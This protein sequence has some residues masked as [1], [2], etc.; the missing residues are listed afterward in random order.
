MRFSAGYETDWIDWKDWCIGCCWETCVSH[1]KNYQ[2][3]LRSSCFFLQ[4]LYNLDV[5]SEKETAR[6][7]S[8]SNWEIHVCYW[9]FFLRKAKKCIRFLCDI[10]IKIVFEFWWKYLELPNFPRILCKRIRQSDS[11]FPPILINKTS[12]IHVLS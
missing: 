9:K 3:Q 1:F 10:F 4:K 2:C 6:M 11:P 8:K 5:L 12:W 7:Q